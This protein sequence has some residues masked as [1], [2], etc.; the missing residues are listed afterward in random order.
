M[1][2]FAQANGLCF[3]IFFLATIIFSAVVTKP[4]YYQRNDLKSV[5]TGSVEDVSQ[6]RRAASPGWPKYFCHHGKCVSRSGKRGMK[7]IQA[8]FVND[9]QNVE[10]PVLQ[11]LD[12]L[13]VKTRKTTLKGRRNSRV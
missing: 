2:N 9:I 10:E 8:K 5:G 4:R 1:K 6:E 12:I 7:R 11:D 3:S 13:P